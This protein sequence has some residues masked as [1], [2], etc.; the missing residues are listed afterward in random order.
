MGLR[1]AKPGSAPNPE[2]TRSLRCLPGEGDRVTLGQ[3]EGYLVLGL[4]DATGSRASTRALSLE[5]GRS[6]DARVG[7]RAELV[8]TLVG[9]GSATIERVE[10]TDLGL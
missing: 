2:P 1:P 10:I 9:A 4:R 5:G 7:E 8:V 6:V 3:P